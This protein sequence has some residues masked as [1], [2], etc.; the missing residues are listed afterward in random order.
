MTEPAVAWNLVYGPSGVVHGNGS[1]LEWQASG[2]TPRGVIAGYPTAM[3]DSFHTVGFTLAAADGVVSGVSPSNMLIGKAKADFSE[4]VFAQVF[5]SSVSVGCYKGGVGGWGVASNYVVLDSAATYGVWPAGSWT[6]QCGYGSV[7]GEY[8]VALN[9]AIQAVGVDVSN[10]VATDSAHVYAGQGFFSGVRAGVEVG[11]CVV[12]AWQV[13]ETP[14][15]VVPAGNLRVFRTS[16]SLVPVSNPATYQQVA[17]PGS[18]FDGVDY[19]SGD[20]SWNAANSTATVS[21]AGVYLA[22]VSLRVSSSGSGGV[23]GG[24]AVLKNGVPCLA[25]P[26]ITVSQGVCGSF[27]VPLLAG[28]T[29][30][31][32]AEVSGGNLLGDP[33][34]MFTYF[35]L[36]RMNS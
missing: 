10:P 6:L 8:R 4:F 20:I 30:S 29:V 9:G 32:G 15:V 26:P 23:V 28:D 34:G 13:A 33:T 25:S 21:S 7:G 5:P 22:T 36:N 31:P 16:Q 1:G 35:G 24:V 3:A 2:S 12:S 27:P 18:F 14:K 19:C 17:L 11:P